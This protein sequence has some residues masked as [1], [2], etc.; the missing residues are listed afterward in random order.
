MLLPLLGKTLTSLI[1]SATL[2][3]QSI[4][5]L[6]QVPSPSVPILEVIKVYGKLAGPV[7]FGKLAPN[8]SSCQITFDDVE[9]GF[10]LN[11]I[12][13]SGS[14]L[15]R[16][17]F[18]ERLAEL[19]FQWPLKPFGVDNSLDKTVGMNKGAETRVYM[20]E[21]EKRG[22]Y[23]RR[24]PAGPL[25]TSLRPQ[26]NAILNKEDI[27]YRAR[28]LVYDA[29]LRGDEQYRREISPEQLERVFRGSM[30]YYGFLDLLGKSSISWPY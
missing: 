18:A 8:G 3:A 26:L 23:D 9:R 29:I 24:N 6:V 14:A 12:K 15:S 7:C 5:P 10:K 22:L 21:L 19:D 2:S 16:E 28:D 30:D 17:Q 11:E 1:I 20:K 25:P 4:E 27:D 13:S